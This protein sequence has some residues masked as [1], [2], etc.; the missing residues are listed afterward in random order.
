MLKR[1]LQATTFVF[2][3]PLSFSVPSP[4]LSLPPNRCGATLTMTCLVL[5]LL[6]LL[7]PSASG[8]MQNFT[9]DD[10]QAEY[11]DGPGCTWKS[12]PNCGDCVAKLDP[13]RT[14]S[15]TW[16]EGKYVASGAEC[17]ITMEFTGESCVPI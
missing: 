1:E 14:H 11:H 13:S 2:S 15:G 10:S 9:I 7:I 16:H 8:A 5:C 6:A 17:S 4:F 12:G 3:L